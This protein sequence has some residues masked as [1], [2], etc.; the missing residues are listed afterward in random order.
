MATLLL[1]L[2]FSFGACVVLTPLARFLAVRFG[3]VDCPDGRRKMH[4]QAT[5][6]A[7]GIVILLSACGALTIALVTPD[8]IGD[9]FEAES[10]F[11]CGFLLA[12]IVICLLGLADDWRGLSGRHKLLGQLVAIGIVMSS[13]LLVRNVRLFDWHLELGLM[14]VPFTAFWLLGAINS[15]NLIDGM[16]GLLSCLGLIISL[17]MAVMA[18]VGEQWAAASVAVALAGALIGFLCYNYP[19]ATIFLGD[20][21]S[22][23]IGLV[24]GVLGIH[25]SLK[26]PATIALAAPVAILTIPIFDTGA[27]IIRRKLTGRSIY[28]SDRGHL[29]HCLL[30]RGLSSRRVLLWI[31]FFCLLTVV[32]ALASL[33][34][35]NELVA[36]VTAL[37]VVGIL[38]TT[39]LFGH[40]EFLLIT[41]RLWT[42]ATSFWQSRPNGKPHQIEVRSQ[43]SADWAALW[44]RLIAYAGELNLK[45]VC[46]DVNAP[47]F[48]EGYHARW[49]RLDDEVED[50][51]LWRV[52]IPLEASG[53]VVGHLALVGQREQES[54]WMRIAAVGKFVEGLEATI[55]P[56]ASA[57]NQAKPVA[58]MPSGTGC[59]RSNC[60]PA[61]D[62]PPEYLVRV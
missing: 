8:P 17:A 42:T 23:L 35:K 19:P 27:A 38:V 34:L 57:V 15:L 59:S 40:A 44:A 9:T 46:L 4:A 52:E 53:Q 37:T 32:G 50:P 26:G 54:V 14:A 20:S 48:H 13:G 31:S 47:F 25:S 39:R 3:I 45:L 2:A 6:V 16:D 55:F 22:M 60:R 33:A 7:G 30:R 11:L 58:V 12:S 5:A 1:I 49:D 28:L 62:C 18:I 51:G 10:R 56:F 29:H 43:G 24:V 21:G 41:D 36:V 61:D